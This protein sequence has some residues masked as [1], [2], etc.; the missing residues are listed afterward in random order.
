MW[1]DVI[2][3]IFLARL[4]PMTVKVTGLKELSQA[5][6][7]LERKVSKRISRNAAAEGARV[8]RDDAKRRVPVDTGELKSNIFIKKFKDKR[9]GF[10]QYGIGLVGAKATYKNTKQNQN[11]GRVGKSYW[12]VDA[13]YGYM[14]EFGYTQIYVRALIDGKWRTPQVKNKNGVKRPMR[15]KTPIYRPAQPFLRPALESQKTVVV[16]TVKQRII[17]EL[18]KE[19]LK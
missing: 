5:L 7:G 13:Y 19:G 17:R 8:I 1:S 18:K 2:I 9:P 11:L 14:I 15:L 12:T 16:E 4:A 10:V 6:A 3:S